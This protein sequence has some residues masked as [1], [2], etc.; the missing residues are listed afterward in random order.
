MLTQPK[1]PARPGGSDRGD[2]G[3]TNSAPSPRR[4]TL[5]R[6]GHPKTAADHTGWMRRLPGLQTL[7]GYQVAWLHHDI[8]AGL[9]SASGDSCRPERVPEH[10]SVRDG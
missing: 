3:V 5:G 7:R 1:M 6:L 10:G 4:P 2:Q 9:P 8:V